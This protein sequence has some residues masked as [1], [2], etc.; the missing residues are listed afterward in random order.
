[1]QTLGRCMWNA[2]I[3]AI[4]LWLLLP[5]TFLFIL[6]LF[7][8]IAGIYRH[9]QFNGAW[10][11]FSSVLLFPG[12]GL[13]AVWWL[14]FAFPFIKGIRAVPKIVWAGLLV[15]L[16]FAILVFA[17]SDPRLAN[18]LASIPSAKDRLMRTSNFGGGP[19]VASLLLI[20]GIWLRQLHAEKGSGHQAS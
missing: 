4:S 12:A 15:G 14:T 9:Q 20:V 18:A 16:A 6:G 3:I 11:F 8:S 17:T 13:A 2:I 1:M 19:V 10:V 7:A 5:T